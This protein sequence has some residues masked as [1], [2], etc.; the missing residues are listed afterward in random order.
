MYILKT[1]AFTL[2]ELESDIRLK[3]KLQEDTKFDLEFVRN[4]KYF[5]LED[6]EDLQDGA[7]IR[8]CVSTQLQ[9][10]K[11]HSKFYS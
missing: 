6:M 11:I 9:N 2:L 4:G 8:V 10:V 5:V 1:T 7:T 3:F